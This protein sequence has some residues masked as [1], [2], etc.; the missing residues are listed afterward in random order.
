[1]IRPLYETSKDLERESAFFADISSKWR[2]TG[3]K[4]NMRCFA[5][6]TLERDSKI[7]GWCEIKCR[8]IRSSDYDTSNIGLIKLMG[9]RDLARHTALP[10]FLCIRWNDMDGYIDIGSTIRDLEFVMWGRKDRNDA[11]DMQ[12]YVQIP[13]KE[14]IQL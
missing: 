6:Y 9:L 13:I 12:P 2:C 7:V 1:M 11:S 5:D 3:K 14:F 4:L 10:V 8:N